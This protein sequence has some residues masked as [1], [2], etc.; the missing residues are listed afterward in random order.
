MLVDN[1]VRTYHNVLDNVDTYR[2]FTNGHKWRNCGHSGWMRHYTLYIDIL[3][4]T[5]VQILLYTQSTN[6]ILACNGL[7]Y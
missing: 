2:I 4:V 1:Q 3:N 7:M 5:R 6:N